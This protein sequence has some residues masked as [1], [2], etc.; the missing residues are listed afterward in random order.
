[1]YIYNSLLCYEVRCILLLWLFRPFKLFYGHYRLSG[2]L[3]FQFVCCGILFLFAK[4]QDAGTAI[5][6]VSGVATV[7]WFS[8]FL[9]YKRKADQ[10]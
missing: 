1:M 8:A 6:V 10:S 7:G 5:M 4:Q 9:Y 3:C 2:Y